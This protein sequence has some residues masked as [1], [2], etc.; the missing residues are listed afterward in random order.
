MSRFRFK[1]RATAPSC[2]VLEFIET[3]DTE[4]EAVDIAKEYAAD[5][6]GVRE[7]HLV[8]KVNLVEVLF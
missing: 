5:Y 3:A 6:L 4:K 7:E 2:E 1:I 8:L